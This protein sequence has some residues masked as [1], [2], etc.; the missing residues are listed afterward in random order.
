MCWPWQIINTSSNL[1]HI[2]IKDFPGDTIEEAMNYCRNIDNSPV[3]PWC[4]YCDSGCGDSQ[5]RKFKRAYCGIS[6]CGHSDELNEMYNK[7]G[8]M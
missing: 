3:G 2:K 7:Y 1:D 4:Y 8:H 6:I 5:K